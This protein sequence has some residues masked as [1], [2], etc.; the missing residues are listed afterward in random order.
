MVFLNFY[1]IEGAVGRTAGSTSGLT[2]LPITTSLLPVFESRLEQTAVDNIASPSRTQTW[3][4]GMEGYNTLNGAAYH[5]GSESNFWA[6]GGSFHPRVTTNHYSAPSPNYEDDS[7]H[8]FHGIEG[9]R[10]SAYSV[11]D[12]DGLAVPSPTEDNTFI[13]NTNMDDA[14]ITGD[15]NHPRPGGS[16][17]G[18]SEVGSLMFFSAAWIRGR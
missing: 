12:V 5:A 6:I 18:F 15:E 13:P 9:S 4:S 16:F 3:G 7:Y 8:T 10:S 11:D 1:A 14:L 2:I 17:Q